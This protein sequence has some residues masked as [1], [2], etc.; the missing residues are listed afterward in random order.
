V[1][2]NAD[3]SGFSRQEQQLLAALVRCHRRKF[4]SKT[5]KALA[6]EWQQPATRLAM[7]LR[8]AITLHR[9]R[10]DDTLPSFSLK[11]DGEGLRLQLAEG[12]RDSHK[13]LLADLEQEAA[14]LQQAGLSLVIN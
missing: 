11:A 14:Y 2:A 8:L 6:E 1:V 10:Q 12:W 3:M 4:S 5:I 9:S 7:L 13:L